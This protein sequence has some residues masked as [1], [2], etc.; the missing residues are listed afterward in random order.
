LLQI[1]YTIFMYGIAMSIIAY[2]ISAIY[3]NIP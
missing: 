2:I 3:V 1:S